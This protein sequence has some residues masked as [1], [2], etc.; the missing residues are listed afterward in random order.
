MSNFNPLL[1]AAVASH[2]VLNGLSVSQAIHAA[3]VHHDRNLRLWNDYVSGDTY[4]F[5]GEPSMSKYL[6][7]FKLIPDEYAVRYDATRNI[8]I[9]KYDLTDCF[10]TD[11]DGDP[12]FDEERLREHP[13]FKDVSF[14]EIE[15]DD[16]N[17]QIIVE[18]KKH[19]KEAALKIF[20]DYLDLDEQENNTC[21]D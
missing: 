16:G 8:E 21:N 18:I 10:T 11:G 15:D 17:T 5:G 20:R 6:E 9:A 19:D 13:R 2:H 3:A 4:D 1:F 14:R 12:I 7:Y